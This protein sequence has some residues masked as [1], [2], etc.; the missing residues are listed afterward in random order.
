MIA[1]KT[2]VPKAFC[3]QALYIL[4]SF[5]MFKDQQCVDLVRSS[6]DRV[7]FT[8]PAYGLVAK[9]Q[10]DNNFFVEY[11][12][13]SYLIRVEKKATN[14]GGYYY[15]L[16]CVNCDGR[17]R[18]LYCIEGLYL[19]RACGNCAYYS[20]QLN[21]YD[22]WSYM[23]SK[24]EYRLEQKG[25]SLDRKPPWIK[26]RTHQRLQRKYQE[27][28]QMYFQQAEAAFKEKYLAIAKL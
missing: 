2:I 11:N 13:G 4:D 14:F 16:H 24:I 19:C 7:S 22:R 1:R 25:G 10:D 26:M 28:E 8:I 18:K 3:S 15:F 6:D 21:P 5:A 23:Q 9:L 12:Q 17:Y 20:Q 27:Y